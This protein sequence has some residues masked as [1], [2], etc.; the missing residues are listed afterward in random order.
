M[1]QSSAPSVVDVD[2]WT[3]GG[4]Y[5]CVA[6]A[7]A[8]R[9]LYGLSKG[10]VAP[11]GCAPALLAVRLPVEGRRRP[12]QRRPLP[13]TALRAACG[14]PSAASPAGTSSAKRMC[15]LSEGARGDPIRPMAHLAFMDHSFLQDAASM[16]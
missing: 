12:L 16:E 8:L 14:A 7:A 2:M 6:C 13:R 5:L 3:R 1:R 11:S 15:L 9:L 10:I 4:H